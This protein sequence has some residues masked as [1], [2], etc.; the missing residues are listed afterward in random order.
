MAALQFGA[1]LATWRLPLKPALFAAAE[2]GVAGVVLDARGELRPEQFGRTAVRQ[3]RKTLEDLNLRVS[4]VRFRS[5]RGYATPEELDRRVQA[6]RAALD[7][8]YQLGTSVVLG[9]I[10]PIPAEESDAR[11]L[12]IEVLS[13]LGNYGNRAGATLA[14]ETGGESGET[15]AK[16]LAEL[17]EGALG[18]DFN[19]GQLLLGGYSATE[20]LDVLAPAVLHV[21]LLDAVASSGVRRGMPVP[22]GEGAVD[23]PAL[24][25]RLDEQGYRGWFGIPA[26]EPDNALRQSGA[27][28]RFLRSL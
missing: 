14:T 28:L 26:T 25:G 17:P 9:A 3:L 10:G 5:R 20:A 8:A 1:D 16:L 24:L 27:V 4:A 23:F 22:A 21:T 19:P 15:L 7:F 2:L 12:L 11:R 13:D 6:T 18:I